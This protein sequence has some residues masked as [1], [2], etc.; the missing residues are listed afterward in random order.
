MRLRRA[1]PKIPAKS[2]VPPRLLLY[3][4]RS[5]PSPSKSTLLQLLIPLHFISPRINT[6]KKPGGGYPSSSPKVLQL[7]TAHKR[8]NSTRRCPRIPNPFMH[9]RALSVTHGGGGACSLPTSSSASHSSVRASFAFRVSYLAPAFSR[10]AIHYAL[11]TTRFP[12]R[13]TTDVTLATTIFDTN[14]LG[15]PRSIAAVL[16][17]SDGHRA[18]LDPGPASTLPRL[19]ELLDARGIGVSDLNAIL[20]THVH[21]DHAG[22]AGALIQQNP[23]LE[24]YVHEAG[25][26]HLADPSKLLASAERLWPGELGHL[27]GETLPVPFENLRM[28]KGGE[29]L[30]LGSRKLEAVFTPGHASHHV[31]YFDSTDGTAFVGDTAG[32]HIEG[33][34]YVVPLT[35]PPDIDLEGWNH[36]LDAIAARKP[37]RLFLTHFGYSENAAQHIAEYR[38]NLK[39]WGALAAKILRGG[40]PEQGALE[41]FV[42][43]TSAEIK[44]HVNG[45]EAK[46]YIFNCG[47]NLSWLGLARHHRKRAERS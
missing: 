12:L 23:N 43:A 45:A 22:A 36:S 33:N 24:I 40:L 16:L 1:V 47:L 37:S 25:M 4:N 3:N 6:Y 13:Y 29:T 8:A 44:M 42:A 5:L 2:S 32:F 26:R 38:K 19:R 18:I 9:F 39:R 30:A 11:P 27:F 31:S 41:A 28:L 10:P 20:L 15:R 46:H 17:E 21:L 7:V 35:P 14:W 34:A